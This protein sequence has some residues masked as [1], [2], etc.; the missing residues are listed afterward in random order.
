[1]AMNITMIA[2]RVWLMKTHAKADTVG[3]PKLKT[4]AAKQI[5]LGGRIQLMGQSDIHR[6]TD[7]RIPPFLGLLGAGCEFAR[8]QFGA[9][10]LPLD[11]VGFL[12]GPIVLFARAVIGQFTAGVIGDLGHSTAALGA[13]DWANGQVENRHISNRAFRLV[14]KENRCPARGSEPSP[15]PAGRT[16]VVGSTPRCVSALR[17]SEKASGGSE[18]SC[19]WLTRLRA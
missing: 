4:E 6:P 12:L 15:P 13:A 19:A 7:P 1:M 17:L 9:D 18:V 3:V 8:L 2:L 14:G 5:P 10:Y 16:R 11:E